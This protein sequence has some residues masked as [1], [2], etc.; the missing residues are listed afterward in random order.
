M[1]RALLLGLL[2]AWGG[3][4]S[5]G[6]SS[7]PP[8]CDPSR[9]V[10]L[11]ARTSAVVGAAGMR[12]RVVRSWP[13]LRLEPTLAFREACGDAEDDGR[14]PCLGPGASIEH[15]AESDSHLCL[16]VDGRTSCVLTIALD[17]DAAGTVYSRL[18]S[19][20]LNE[21]AA[22]G[23]L[24]DFCSGDFFSC[25]VR[26]AD[27]GLQ[28]WGAHTACDSGV[29]SPP[30]ADGGFSHVACGT[31][32]ACALTALHGHVLCWGSDDDGQGQPP[33]GAFSAVSAGARH[34]CGLRMDGRVLCW[35]SDQGV[36]ES[37]GECK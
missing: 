2:A 34:T 9:M 6:G 25:G 8:C 24:S 36:G 14:P 4:G 16:R 11:T 3:G 28:C 33:A 18:E 23:Q 10:A 7:G 12:D 26:A 29:C 31:Y 19:G 32:H 13:D 30:S 5:S 20:W 1:S 15:L 17:K 27:R 21:I 22:A 35:G 37:E